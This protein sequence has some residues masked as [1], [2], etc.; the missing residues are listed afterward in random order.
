MPILAWT[1]IP[2]ICASLW[3]WN[4]KCAS[5]GIAIGWDGISWTFCPVLQ[6]SLCFSSS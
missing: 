3:S 1:M 2:L 6:I 4:D 5:L